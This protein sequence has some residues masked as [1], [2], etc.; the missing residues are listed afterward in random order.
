MLDAF[1]HRFSRL[2]LALFLLSAVVWLGGTVIRAAIGYDVFVPGTIEYKSSMSDAE[3]VATIRLF[4]S[5]AAYTG[6]AFGVASLC[7]L[8]LTF[9][10]RAVYA[11]RG[12]MLMMAIL[13][14]LLIPMQG[15][16]FYH[17]YQLAQHFDLTTDPMIPLLATNELLEVFRNRIADVGL[18]M[19]N[20]L[21]ILSGITIITLAAMRPLERT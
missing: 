6:W 4:V 17:D 2:M 7:V 3:R 18:A 12:W 21:S 5:T 1:Q 13:C 16:S 8:V 20:G 15:W 11:R 9:T 10:Q 19:A 14:W